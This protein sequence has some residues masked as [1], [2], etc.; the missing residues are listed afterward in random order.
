M[1]GSK[2]LLPHWNDGEGKFPKALRHQ[3]HCLRI[4]IHELDKAGVCSLYSQDLTSAWEKIY[5][6]HENTKTL[7]ARCKNQGA[8]VNVIESF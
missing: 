4:E 2:V 1:P 6:Y 8:D 3:L 5:H 7:V